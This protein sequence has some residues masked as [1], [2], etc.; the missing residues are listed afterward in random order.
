MD[1]VGLWRYQHPIA[2][3][4]RLGNRLFFFQVPSS[5]ADLYGFLLKGGPIFKKIVVKK[6]NL[7]NIRKESLFK[8]RTK[9][10]HRVLNS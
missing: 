10:M 1:E 8:L 9:V 3:F 4:T 7:K 6:V 2:R 5:S